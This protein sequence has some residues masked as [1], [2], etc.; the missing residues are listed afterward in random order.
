[1]PALFQLHSQP[2]KLENPPQKFPHKLPSTVTQQQNQQ[3]TQQQQRHQQHLQLRNHQQ[4]PERPYKNVVLFSP[5]SAIP[6]QELTV[7]MKINLTLYV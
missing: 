7:K 1:M 3:E 4:S 2:F 6:Q 5:Y